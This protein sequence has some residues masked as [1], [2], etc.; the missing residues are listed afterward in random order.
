VL[1]KKIL[2]DN[3]KGFDSFENKINF[4]LSDN[5][6][7]VAFLTPDRKR[8][9]VNYNMYS[10]YE[11]SGNNII[12]YDKAVFDGKIILKFDNTIDNRIKLRIS[13]ENNT[14]NI[15][16]SITYPQ[17]IFNCDMIGNGGGDSIFWPSMEGSI[18][19]DSSNE[20]LKFVEESYGTGYCGICPGAATMQYMAFFSDC[21]NL[22]Y[23]THDENCNLKDFEY[24]FLDDNKVKFI[25][26]LYVGGCKNYDM[27]Y[28]ILIEY[29][30][31]DWQD[32]AEIYRNWRD[33]SAMDFPCKLKDRNDLPEWLSKSPVTMLYPVR[34]TC[35]TDHDEKMTPN[36]YY[37]YSNILPV[38][39]RYSE[40][41]DSMVMPLMMHWEGSAPWCTPYIWPPYGDGDDFKYTVE[42]IHKKG[43]IV[44]LY[45]SGLGITTQAVTDSSYTNFDEYENGGWKEVTCKDL[46]EEL[47]FTDLGFVRSGYDVCP[48]CDKVKNTVINETMKIANADVDYFQA[49]DQNLGGIPRYCWSENHSHPAAPGKWLVDSMTELFSSMQT[50]INKAGKNMVFG[51]ELAASE[52]AIKHLPF[53]DLRWFT[54]FRQG[55][56]VP[57]YSYIYH[58]Y[59]NNY[60]GN[61]NG[62]Q[63]MLNL[64]AAPDNL[65]YRTAYSF[66]NGDMLTITLGDNGKIS[67]CWNAP[68]DGSYPDEEPIVKLIKNGNAW[69][70]S[71]ADKYL[72]FG[73]MLKTDTAICDESV[74][75]ITADGKEIKDYNILTRKYQADDG[76]IAQF[77]VNRT[78]TTQEIDLSSF[79]KSDVLYLS[80]D[81]TTQIPDK[82]SLD[83]ADIIC[84][85]MN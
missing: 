64:D 9:F 75:V 23:G 44:G 42:Q 15:I 4:S 45:A 2:F 16:E 53:N 85:I 13:V 29:F 73:K 32:A 3:I 30:S 43:H 79:D 40:E 28:D 1:S 12:F 26:R 82:I 36:C 48:T 25:C 41:F 74:A 50:E 22:Y 11:T 54:V 31:G 27:P 78:S 37:P 33:N 80:P 77:F 69:R 81:K 10:S 68:F 60:M 76:S 70:T 5:L 55:K 34:G 66:I 7:E 35:D 38:L 8:I 65:I 63:W 72:R 57:A 19:E 46:N 47:I 58:E 56:P 21:G 61:Q 6:F 84:I 39:D 18:I 59:I 20:Y 17:I 71:F 62:L 24:I 49:F 67:W 51:C 14:E 83:S 52:P